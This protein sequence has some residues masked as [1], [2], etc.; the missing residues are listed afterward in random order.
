MYKIYISTFGQRVIKVD[1][2]VPIE[3]GAANR[4]NF[5]YQLHDNTGENI[6]TENEYYGELT[7]LYWI[8]K[9]TDIQDDDI[10]GFCHYNKCLAISKSNA[11]KT[12]RSTRKASFVLATV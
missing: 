1:G 7:G 5:I 11:S 2:G 3:V 9:N 12:I 8:W 10:V 6:S 4:N